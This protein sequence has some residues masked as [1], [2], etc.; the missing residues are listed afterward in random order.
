MK[1]DSLPL[2]NYQIF[3][4]NSEGNLRSSLFFT[5]NSTQIRHENVTSD[6]KHCN[7]RCNL[8]QVDSFINLSYIISYEGDIQAYVDY[9]ITNVLQ[10]SLLGLLINTLK[11][12]L[13]E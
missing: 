5:S 7:L 9:K 11:P 4:S 12:Y 2:A 6:N 8:E 13:S 1:L 10:V 3:V